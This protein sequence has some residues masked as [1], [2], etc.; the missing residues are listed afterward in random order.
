MR[1]KKFIIAML[2]LCNIC[3]IKASKKSPQ[4]SKL[5]VEFYKL[6]Y[7]YNFSQRKYNEGDKELAGTFFKGRKEEPKIHDDFFKGEIRYA[8][9]DK[10]KARLERELKQLFRV[11]L[12]FGIESE[13]C[14]NKLRQEFINSIRSHESSLPF[15]LG[16]EIVEAPRKTQSKSCFDILGFQEMQGTA[17]R[18]VR[19]KNLL[20]SILV[21]KQLEQEEKKRNGVNSK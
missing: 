19:K 5:E 21:I 17:R 20:M 13:N 6:S 4:L 15:L 14:T 18:L 12:N 16:S 9:I 11:L 8:K 3:S 2:I 7:G 10:E 1:K